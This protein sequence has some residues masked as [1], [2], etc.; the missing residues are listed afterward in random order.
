MRG[1]ISDSWYLLKYSADQSKK[2]YSFVMKPAC[3][4]VVQ[5]KRIIMHFHVKEGFFNVLQVH[6]IEY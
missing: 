1:S 2:A 4:L 6:C 3:F 5:I